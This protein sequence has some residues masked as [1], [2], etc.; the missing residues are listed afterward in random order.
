MKTLWMI[1]GGLQQ[2]RVIEIART[3]GYRI[4]VSD[5]D[6]DCECAKLADEFLCINGRDIE[7]L[8]SA[9]R[10]LK[11]QNKLDGVF[12]FTELT[13]S[14]A[15][16]SQALA[17][18]GSPLIG[19][20]NCQDKGL[21][22]NIW[23]SKK[24]CTP[25][26]FLY[27]GSQDCYGLVS[28]L[29]YPI[30]IKPVIGS[31]GFGIIEIA[32]R[33]NFDKW[34]E[35]FGRHV[36]YNSRVVIEEKLDGTSHDVNGMI[37]ADGKFHAYGIVDRTFTAGC[38]VEDSITA[39]TALHSGEQA[40]LYDLL[41]AS[42]KALGV[43]SGPVKG[44]A[45]LTSEGFKML[46]VA[47]RLHGPKFSLYAM[48][49]VAKNYLKGFFAVLAGEDWCK[50]FEID[51]SGTAFRSGLIPAS[52]GVI[53]SISGLDELKKINGVEVML[54]KKIGDRLADVLSSHDAFGYVL[55]TGGTHEHTGNLV[56]E[57]IGA[58]KITTLASGAYGDEH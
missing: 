50:E 57:A 52:P 43:D 3:Y 39:P 49:A 20:V 37:D 27:S 32:D 21:T 48:P 40:L 13:T 38:F 36:T 29:R 35:V 26:G 47:T 8:L 17:L 15:A 23:N 12:T 4:I 34:Y 11:D 5:R 22:K 45:I 54:F 2:R 42:V 44:D 1:G 53:Q 30:L 31:G 6:E 24:I 9:G 18:P 19:S 16:L 25:K 33:V 55:A 10:H 7:G 56:R 14:V 51:W 58:L 41:E 28:E 46:E